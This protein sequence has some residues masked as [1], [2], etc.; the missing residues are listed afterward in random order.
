M[1]TLKCPKAKS[2]INEF[3]VLFNWV[4]I[5]WQI[6]SVFV[7]MLTTSTA[8]PFIGTCKTSNMFLASMLHVWKVYAIY[9]C[10][11]P[12]RSDQ[13]SLV[14]MLFFA[15]K[16][17]FNYPVI[18]ILSSR[19]TSHDPRIPDPTKKHPISRCFLYCL[20]CVDQNPSTLPRCCRW[21]FSLPSCWHCVSI[22]SVR[23]V[24]DGVFCNPKKW[25]PKPVIG[26]V[27]W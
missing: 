3:P 14:I 25:V 5:P 9:K 16:K 7:C 8:S 10:T 22:G 11:L 13:K 4:S 17:G 19:F 18:H 1:D 6:T 27:L 23:V 26:D 20:A 12:N 24:W 15:T 21:I 2:A